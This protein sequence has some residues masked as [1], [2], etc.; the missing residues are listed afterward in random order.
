M[1]IPF[2]QS[3][4]SCVVV[5]LT[6]YLI[7]IVLTWTASVSSILYIRLL[8]SL[9]F[10]FSFLDLNNASDLITNHLGPINL[11]M[12]DERNRIVDFVWAFSRIL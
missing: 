4:Y 1:K 10:L 2:L 7:V 5:V 3:V 8:K 6:S 12:F 11:Y 9:H